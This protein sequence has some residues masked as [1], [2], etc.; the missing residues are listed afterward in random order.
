MNFPAT[1]SRAPVRR[2]QALTLVE[3]MITL[4]IFMFVVLG[5]TSLHLF[6]LRWNEMVKVKLSASEGARRAVSG[7][8][9]EIHGAGIVNI[10]SGD[11]TGF[12]N[13]AFNTVQQG[14]A[15]EI[16]PVKTNSELFV[17]YYLDAAG[18]QLKRLQFGAPEPTVIASSIT[19]DIVFT[20]EDFAGTILS[21]NFNNRVIGVRL[22]FFQIDNPFVPIG[23]G[24]YF[25]FYELQTRVTRR[26]LE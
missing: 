18:H 22:Q 19:N 8:V 25:D 5:M 9:T 20:A 14:N 23:R 16:Y 1:K 26:A 17:R 15:I 24:H 2:E 11:E 12:T 21:N 13:A 3:L 6:G 4:G 10:G 7:L